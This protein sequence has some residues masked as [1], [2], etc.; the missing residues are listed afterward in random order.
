MLAGR[1]PVL[2]TPCPGRFRA[3]NDASLRYFSSTRLALAPVD[4]ANQF[5]AIPK[6]LVIT[7]R[8]DA[9]QTSLRVA[10]SV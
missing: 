2:T 4:Q 3:G 1:L 6:Q 5:K 7:V 9:S 8:L 10:D